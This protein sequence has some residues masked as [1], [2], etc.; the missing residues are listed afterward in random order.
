MR[1]FGATRLGHNLGD[2]QSFILHARS[3]KRSSILKIAYKHDT[4]GR[5]DGCFGGRLVGN[6]AG[7]RASF[8]RRIGRRLMKV[9]IL[10]LLFQLSTISYANILSFNSSKTTQK[11]TLRPLQ[12]Q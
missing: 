4:K 10:V 1:S 12:N 9:L 8:R 11:G 6:M 2:I 3:G 7:T 5:S